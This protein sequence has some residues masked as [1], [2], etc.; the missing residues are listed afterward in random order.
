MPTG[1]CLCGGVKIAYTGP[2][3]LSV[4]CHCTGCKRNSGSAFS[5]NVV[6]PNGTFRLVAGATM[7]KT[8]LKR[9]TATGNVGVN[10]FCGNCGTTLWMDTMSIPGTKIVKAGVMEGDVMGRARPTAEFFSAERVGWVQAVYGAS[11]CRTMQ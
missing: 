10:Y 4:L 5:T 2:P 6:V 9:D 11:Q 3:A 8:F 7:L 1:S